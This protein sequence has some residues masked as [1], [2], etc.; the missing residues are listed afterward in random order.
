MSTVLSTSFACNLAKFFSI[1]VFVAASDISKD[2]IGTLFYN[3]LLASWKISTNLNLGVTNQHY[4]KY[5][6]LVYHKPINV[7]YLKY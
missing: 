3:I 7:L 2:G 5:T 4:K 1:Q 6:N